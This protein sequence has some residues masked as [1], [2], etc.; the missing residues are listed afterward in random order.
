MVFKKTKKQQQRSINPSLE[1]SR[2]ANFLGKS[3][4]HNS[5][6]SETYYDQLLE[7]STI[8]DISTVR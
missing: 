8:C 1:K 3:D 6:C 5:L 7:V 4:F 2:F